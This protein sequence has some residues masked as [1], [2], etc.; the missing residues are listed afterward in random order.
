MHA[1]SP[2]FTVIIPFG[3]SRVHLWW[4]FL[5]LAQDVVVSPSFH[6]QPPVGLPFSRTLSFHL[7]DLHQ[8]LGFE[9]VDPTCRCCRW[10]RSHG[11]FGLSCEAGADDA[12]CFYFKSAQSL[13]LRG[14]MCIHLKNLY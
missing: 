1:M 11:M 5:D 4:G 10:S 12:R 8:V 14:N 7:A 3:F 2:L 6:F 13:V 9:I